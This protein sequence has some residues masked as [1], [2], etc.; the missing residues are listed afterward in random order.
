MVNGYGYQVIECRSCLEEG[1]LESPMMPHEETINI[2]KQMD[3]LRKEW[4][5][6]YPMDR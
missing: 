5:V 4:G 6:K 1:V 2:M 3:E